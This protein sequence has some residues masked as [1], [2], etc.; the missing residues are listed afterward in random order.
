MDKGVIIS[1]LLESNI[2]SFPFDFDEWPSTHANPAE[3]VRS[4]N[5]G[6][7][8][9]RYHYKDVF[10][11]PDFDAHEISEKLDDTDSTKMHKIAYKINILPM[12]DEH[13]VED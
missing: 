13:V 3:E 1:P 12:I 6:I 8:N 10:P 9:L 2:F 5:Q 4:Y 7:F 11:E